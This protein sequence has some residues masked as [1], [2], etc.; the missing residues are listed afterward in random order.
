MNSWPV[1]PEVVGNKKGGILVG[2]LYQGCALRWVN[3]P[4]IGCWIGGYYPA[5]QFPHGTS[6][7]QRARTFPGV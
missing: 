2:P 6:P 1:G 7:W 4:L 3:R 5:E